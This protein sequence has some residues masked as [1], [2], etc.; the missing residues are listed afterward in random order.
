MTIYRITGVPYR[1]DFEL[2][3]YAP[4]KRRVTVRRSQNDFAY[5]E[6]AVSAKRGLVQIRAQNR[7]YGDVRIEVLDG[8]WEVVD[9]DR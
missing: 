9:E 7:N 3:T 2:R 4:G 6:D 1:W 5:Y 8:E